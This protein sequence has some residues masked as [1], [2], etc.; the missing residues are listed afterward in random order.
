[1]KKYRF[2]TVGIVVFMMVGTTLA[3]ALEQAPLNP[4]FLQ[5]QVQRKAGRF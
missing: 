1:M 4:E 2:L 5:Y 3:G